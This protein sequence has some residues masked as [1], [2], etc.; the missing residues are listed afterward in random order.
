MKD[1]SDKDDKNY[2]LKINFIGSE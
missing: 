2:A 1:D